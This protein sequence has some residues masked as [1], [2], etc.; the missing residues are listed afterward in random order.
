M[1]NVKIITKKVIL[2]T[3]MM[4]PTDKE[5][6]RR[7]MASFKIFLDANLSA[8]FIHAGWKKLLMMVP[9]NSAM[10][11]APSRPPGI[12]CTYKMDTPARAKQMAMPKINRALSFVLEFITCTS[13]ILF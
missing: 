12:K 4:V 3:D 2:P 11:D 8:G 13:K 6:P 7:M 5:A 1:A 10:I 9:I